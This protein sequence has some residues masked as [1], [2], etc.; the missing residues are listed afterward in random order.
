MK[1]LLL[2]VALLGIFSAGISAETEEVEGPTDARGVIM[3]AEPEQDV[4]PAP[5]PS[6]DSTHEQYC[7]D[8]REIGTAAAARRDEGAPVDYVIGIL[9]AN[10]QQQFIWTVRQA[11]WPQSAGSW[12]ETVGFDIWLRCKRENMD[13]RK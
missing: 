8:A 13:Y 4:E 6:I 3:L 7:A 11:Y 10:H 9:V 5:D 1:K 2:A 12:P